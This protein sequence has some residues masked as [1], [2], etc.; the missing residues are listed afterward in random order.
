MRAITRSRA[1][2]RFETALQVEM[3]GNHEQYRTTAE[4][5]VGRFV[6]KDRKSVMLPCLK[7]GGWGRKGEHTCREMA[8]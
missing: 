2:G 1:T 7:C 8:S 3:F 5:P 4:E 6:K